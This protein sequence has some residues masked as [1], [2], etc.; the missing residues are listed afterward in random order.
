MGN[1]LG[2]SPAST[3]DRRLALQL[4]EVAP[5]GLPGA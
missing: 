5:A 1:R 2:W 4:P 3:W